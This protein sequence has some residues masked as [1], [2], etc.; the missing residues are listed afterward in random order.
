MLA[1]QRETGDLGVVEHRVF[2]NRLPSLGGVA[3]QAAQAFGE[4]PMG[5]ALEA[6][7]RD[8][9]ARNDCPQSQE[10]DAPGPSLARPHHEAPP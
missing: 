1:L 10:N 4:G 9:G 5:V 2:L 7:G 6:L 3:I 8:P